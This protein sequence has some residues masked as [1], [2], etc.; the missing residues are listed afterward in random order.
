VQLH[1]GGFT[2]AVAALGTSLCPGQRQRLQRAGARRLVIAFDGDS[3]GVAACGRLIAELRPLA[4]SGALELAVLPIPAGQDPDG[5]LRQEGAAAFRQRLAVAVHWLQWE[6]DQLL[7]PA[8]AAPAD[9]AVLQRCDH[10]AAQLLALLPAGALRHRAEQRLQQA[11]GAVPNA[12][13]AAPVALEP[14]PETQPGS[15]VVPVERQRAERRALRLYLCSAASRELLEQLQLQDPLCRQ[16]MDCLQQLR[17]RL[18]AAGE[19]TG[20]PDAPADPL[21]ALAQALCPQLN[22]VLSALLE[23][24]L[25]CGPDVRRLL[26]QQPQPELQ[27]VLE[28]LEPGVDDHESIALAIEV[29]RA[30]AI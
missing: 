4:I 15:G 24:L 6:L 29:R 2:Q 25:Q 12:P 23:G 19:L 5:L 30:K 27:A 16:A 1:Q 22:P 14:R 3:A 21:P 20:D 8:L 7:A 13:L 10:Q 17:L 9:L 11:L 28:V 26:R 18:V